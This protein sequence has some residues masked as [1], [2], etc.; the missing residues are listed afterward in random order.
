MYVE[1]AMR[2][3]YAL[4]KL[5]ISTESLRFRYLRKD[6]QRL[7]LTSII[8]SNR[9]FGAYTA[10][11]HCEHQFVPSCSQGAQYIKKD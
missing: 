1:L 11:Y 9:V 6:V 10:R 3:A 7:I 8:M 5:I 2:E 4:D